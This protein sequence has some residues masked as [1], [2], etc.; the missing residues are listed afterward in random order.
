[1]IEQ[2]PSECHV[3][4]VEVDEEA[5]LQRR[6]AVVRTVGEDLLVEIAAATDDE[7]A[8][9]QQVVVAHRD[10][11]A[12]AGLEELGE[13]Q[14]IGDWLVGMGPHDDGECPFAEGELIGTAP[15]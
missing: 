9:V 7:L 15:A 4:L 6:I 14:L 2:V 1:M 5:D 11:T 3:D 12:I 8:L 10:A 13:G